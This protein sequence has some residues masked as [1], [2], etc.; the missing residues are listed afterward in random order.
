MWLNSL[1]HV[2]PVTV[3][4]EGR[5]AHVAVALQV[6]KMADVYLV[7]ILLSLL[8]LFLV[9]FELRSIWF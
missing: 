1:I 4:C 7:P 6:T 2:F 8:S 3:V 9:H 5:R